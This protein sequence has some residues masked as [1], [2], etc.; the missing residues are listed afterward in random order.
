MMALTRK[1]SPL[2]STPSSLP[3]TKTKGRCV[4]FCYHHGVPLSN[5]YRGGKSGGWIEHLFPSFLLLFLF[6]LLLLLLLFLLLLLVRVVL[7]GLVGCFS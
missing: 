5:T 6:S 3:T 4:P 2:E 7:G 1:R